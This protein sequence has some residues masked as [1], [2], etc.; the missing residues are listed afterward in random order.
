MM[1]KTVILLLFLAVMIVSQTACMKKSKFLPTMPACEPDA[2]EQDNTPG[3]AKEI[4]V[5]GAAQ[6]RNSN[7]ACDY[8]FV[9]I[10]M[11]AGASFTITTD[12]GASDYCDTEM[13]LYSTDGK[14][15]L[16]Y[17]DD[18]GPGKGSQINYTAAS[19]GYYFVRISQKSC[20]TKFGTGTE[21]TLSVTS[22]SIIA[23][24]DFSA[25]PSATPT[26]TVIP[27]TTTATPTITITATPG[28]DAYEPDDTAAQA[29][30]VQADGSQQQHNSF[31][32]CDYDWYKFSAFKYMQYTI[33]TTAMGS[34]SAVEI[35]LYDT[36]GT[37]Q[38]ANKITTSRG[39][40]TTLTWVA[41][42]DGVYYV[43]INQNACSYY[44]GAETQ[45]TV[46]FSSS[47]YSMTPTSTPAVSA[48]PSAP[49]AY[50]P[51]DT[52]AQARLVTVGGPAEEHNSNTAC[53]YDWYKFSAVKD[54]QYSI[55]TSAMGSNSAVYIYLYGTDAATQLASAYTNI[56][57]AGTTLKWT[58]PADGIYYVKVCQYNCSLYFGADTEYTIN[59]SASF[60]TLTVTPT[61][62]PAVT[63]TNSATPTVTSTAAGYAPDAYEP[64]DSPST[65]R[66]ITIGGAVE[67]HNSN[68]PCDYD[69]FKFS[70]V[71]NRAYTVQ[72]EI[73][74][75]RSAA[76]INIYDT[77]GATQL[78]SSCSYTR[79]NG[80]TLTWIAPAD[81]IYFVKI[82]QYDCADYYGAD[83]EYT[84]SFTGT[85]FAMTPTVT[86][87]ITVTP[88]QYEDDGSAAKARLITAGGPAEQHNS[89]VPCDMDWYKFQASMNFQYTVSTADMGVNSAVCIY[90][91]DVDGY[92]L[93][94]QTCGTTRGVGST[95]SWTAPRDGVYYVKIFQNYCYNF[96]GAGT[97]YTVSFA[98][99]GTPMTATVTRTASP[100]FTVSVPTITPTPYPADPYEDD[101]SAAKARLVT[102]GGQAETHNSNVA[103][104]YDWYK[105][106]AVSGIPYTIKTYAM[107]SNS[108]AEIDI[109]DTNGYTLLASN[110]SYS[111]GVPTT[112][113]WTAPADGIY[114]VRI[115]QYSCFAYYGANTE[116]T[117]SFTGGAATVTPSVINTN[118]F[119]F[120]PTNSPTP[121]MT[122]TPYPPD[123]YEDDGSAAKAR[124]IT[125]G[126]A[127]EQHNSNVACDDDWFKF[128]AVKNILYTIKTTGMGSNS[129]VNI[130]LYSTDGYT[131]LATAYTYSAGT[132]TTLSW[133]APA[134]GVYFVKAE[135]SGCSYTFGANTEYTISFTGS[136]VTMTPT[137]TQTFTPTPTNT[138]SASVVSTPDIY[139]DDD[140]AGNARL[141]TIGAAPEQHNSHDACDYDWFKFSAQKNILYT[142]RT[143]LMGSN[144]AAQITIYSTDG[145][146]QLA[147]NYSYQAG[148]GTLLN[149]VAP[150]DGIYYAKINQYNCASVYGANTEYTVWFTGSDSTMT[151][152]MTVTL[153]F[154]PSFTPVPS[155]TV[156]PDVYE[157]D[158]NAANAR[159]VTVGGAPEQHN[160]H[161]AC[162]YDWYKFSAAKSIEY[163]IS[164]TAMGSNSAVYIYIYDTDGYSQLAYRYSS[165]RGMGT[166]ITWTAPADGVYF[167][168]ICQYD[169]ANNYGL[170][171]EYTVSF[172]GSSITMTPTLTFTPTFTPT[173]TFTPVNTP[174]PTFTPTLYPADMY[175]D[176]GSAAKARLVT[177]GGAPESHNSN[178]PCDADWFKFSAL[179]G[180]QY[181]VKTSIAGSNSQACIYI[182]DTDGFTQL[183]HNCPGSSGMG[184]SIAWTATSD[185]VYYV[186]I[187]ESNCNYV[188]GAN[189]E[190][191]VA[192]TAS[193]VTMTP[194]VTQTLT[195]TPSFTPTPVNTPGPDMYEDDGT[196]LKAR[197]VAVNGPAET[198]NSNTPCDYDWFKFSAIKG[199]PYT[200]GTSAMGTNSAVQ[201]YIFDIDGSTYLTGAYSYTNGVPTTLTWIAPADGVYF[202]RI[203]QYSCYSNYGAGTEY[204]VSF[205]SP[206]LTVTPTNSF[207]PAATYTASSTP[208]ATGTPYPADQYEDDDT[209]ANARYIICGSA[210]ETHNSHDQCDND[211]YKF[212]ASKNR[213][214]T[215]KTTAMGSNSAVLIALYS[216]D[217]AS[218]LTYATSYTLGTG[219]TLNWTAA[220]DGVYY[221]RVSQSNCYSSFGANTEYNISFAESASTVTPVY[222]STPTYTP[223]VSYTPTLTYVPDMYEDDSSAPKARLITVNGAAETHNSNVPCDYDWFKFSALK[224]VLYTVKTTAMGSNSA[225]EIDILDTDGYTQLASGVT[226]TRGSGTT[227]SFAAPADGVYYV[228]IYQTYCTSYYGANTEYTV[229]FTSS[230]ITMTPSNTATFTY[231]PTFTFTPTL[232]PTAYPPD[233]YEPDNTASQ[234]RLVTVGDA[235][236]THTSNVACDRDW[237]KFAAVKST[238]YTIATT[239][240][241]SSSAVVVEIFDTNGSTYLAEAYTYTLGT[242]T[243]LNWIAPAD[244]VYYVEIYQSSCSSYYGANT[245]YT[246]SFTASASTMT[247]TFTATAS[248][249]PTMTAT[250]IG[251]YPPDIYEDD[252]S[253]AK[254][255]PVT[256]GGAPE[257]HNSHD[258][259]DND[260][261]KFAAASGIQYNIS[262]TAMG[263]N[264]AVYIYIYDTDG[265]TVLTS[266]YSTV[267]GTGTS[268]NW[269]APADGT[270]YVKICQY[271][272][273]SY[274]G[275]NTDYT[276]AFTGSA[277][278]MTPTNT[279]TPT[280]TYTNTYTPTMTPTPFPPD[281]YED[282]GSAAKA[283]LMTVNGAPETH[284]SSSA[285]DY[286]WYKFAAS[287][288]TQYTVKTSAMG[289]NSSV[290]IILYDT[291]GFTQLASAYSYTKGTGTTLIWTAL[292]AGVYYAKIYQYNCYSQYGANTQYTVAFTTP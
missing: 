31:N 279:F 143:G 11:V 204:T 215:I 74:G 157:N 253:A 142:V 105:F 96:F 170:N 247:P 131:Q 119:T 200:I 248:N 259:C 179:K 6:N 97:E 49:D 29:Q 36:D 91:Y 188:Y 195:Y 132:G 158:D 35:Y 233:I 222:T 189:T 291:D 160:S 114:Y 171:T 89:D 281:I 22:S 2:Y 191:T 258:A 100:T 178:T 256:V 20:A 245:Q 19:N 274:Y 236:E 23:T 50:E 133:V 103:C 205:T 196:V 190:Y 209:A 154:T 80:T 224:N 216:T 186:K 151:P 184:T 240:M 83:T 208:T 126:G 270:Y 99:S 174:V 136:A 81:G 141:I 218:E 52:S 65:A 197:L 45:Y 79:G 192:F 211:W 33:K 3:D 164:T 289:T 261:Y 220:S 62:T 86:P 165:I 199:V 230:A 7:D 13:Y 94:A 120:T 290:Y 231:T 148:V 150:A 288:A 229:A 17:D 111:R 72:T 252:D 40:G 54:A 98:V 183:A 155:A 177:V 144:S 112:L 269:V 5:N 122:Q 166:T 46:S 47:V 237:Y 292:A 55:G 58:A 202:V 268:I 60:N 185:G 87:T 153:T 172:A 203:S 30:L 15:Q 235:P 214:Y 198:H 282:D 42:A 266:A 159:L 275:A 263:S 106:A 264:S 110:Y 234:A 10:K 75:Y 64:D 125:V 59:F 134:D 232:S 135:Q 70:A 242:G 271:N 210:P 280:I 76:C 287:A 228:R 156:A 78:A 285:C 162:D 272:C 267:R 260:W 181:T 21:Y 51:D 219:T 168:K 286:D 85:S 140:T 206:M 118:T 257:A 16:A 161:D 37:T 107:G 173:Y 180:I 109:Y 84:V 27:G 255:R 213:V 169:C 53:D 14:T 130:T 92:T 39:A 276:V 152:T 212:T 38:L 251:T 4:T 44:F 48:T 163:T 201:I 28:T 101:D 66:L 12:P 277:I 221:I 283:R 139:E 138:A 24:P 108:A 249:T 217:G 129:A 254:A 265:Y 246:V 9:K 175:E 147:S 182:Y 104:D 238:Q 244:G 8:D 67:Q 187:I 115:S 243:T 227:V 127:S 123:A 149:W 239:A 56:R 284:N 225:V 116:Y 137:I 61:L 194:T 128:S 71:K 18:S 88:D 82:Y 63:S 262:T 41:P 25:T 26:R 69:W 146:T 241:G 32:A 77:D 176:D 121:T 73:M 113:N 102:V 95:L 167:V 193:S 250:A 124:L 273:A 226:Y 207:T 117:V 1:K 34:N 90:I 43:R 93:L 223:T 145:T 278:T 57:G 68:K